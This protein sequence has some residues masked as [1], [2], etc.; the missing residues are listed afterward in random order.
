LVM[1]RGCNE[2]LL[3]HEWRGKKTRTHKGSEYL[4]SHRKKN[5]R[6]WG[7]GGWGAKGKVRVREKRTDMGGKAIGLNGRRKVGKEWVA[8]F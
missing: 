4:L 6:R 7:R 1:P 3:N 2:K 5:F 8:E